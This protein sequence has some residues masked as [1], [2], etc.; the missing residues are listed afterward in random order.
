MLSIYY[1][2]YQYYCYAALIIM[3]MIY[4]LLHKQNS[5]CTEDHLL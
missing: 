5:T 1:Y 2:H 3:I 4:K